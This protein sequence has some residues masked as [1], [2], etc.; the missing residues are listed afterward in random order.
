MIKD[1]KKA[2]E[3]AKKNR[4]KFLNDLIDFVRIP[5]VSTN[6]DNKSDIQHAAEWVSNQLQYL[7]M[8]NI[9]IMPTQGHPVVY[10]ESLKAGKDKPTA[11][12]Y[13]HYDVQPAEP[14]E[15]WETPA[16]EA[17]QKG[18]NLYG[19]GA[20]DMKGQIVIS[21]KAI[22]AINQQEP[23][24][25]NV[26]FLIEGEEEIGSPNLDEFITNNKPLLN[27]DFVINPD[28]GIISD[29]LP[30]ITYGLRGLAY[31]ELRIFGPGHDLHS[32]TYGGVVHNPAQVLSDLIS[33]MHDVNGKINLPR[34]YDR[35]IP[36]D[37]NERKEL[38]RLPL[39]EKFYQSQTGA[40]VLW[41][42]KGYTP[43][44]RI[45][46]RPTLEING[47][48]SGFTGEGSKTVLPF[49]A[50]AKISMRL[51]PDQ[52]PY[53]VK[54]QLS[55]YLKQ[56]APS[57]VTWELEQ[58]SCAYPSL[59]DRSAEP[60]KAL[61][62]AMEQTWGRKPVYRREGGTVPIV[63]QMQRTLGVDSVITGF[64]LPDDNLHAPNEKIHLPTFFNG[65][66]TFIRYY[67]LLGSIKISM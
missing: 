57:S 59:T 20:S 5:S 50:M 14:L 54:Q 19:R 32:G 45:G 31:F 3:Y 35:I 6:P 25:F 18:E 15:L 58:L 24:P 44:E 33:G 34:F 63:A 1:N 67:Y 26:K 64:G 66:E 42:E 61:E 4:E 43:Y 11:L 47:I 39:D 55:D 21:L 10:A 23:L 22:E 2:L 40:E 53:E 8:E 41:G 48:L 46:V 65:I 37:E 38:G 60:V 28:G 51:V 36:L 49:K 29:N 56:N 13:G 62:Q 17:T 12:I 30:T 7:G 16:F 9:R 52:D 27:C